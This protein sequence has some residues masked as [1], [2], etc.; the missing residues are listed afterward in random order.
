MNPTGSSA[1]TMSRQ[2]IQRNH[3]IVK[4]CKA[5]L[6]VLDQREKNAK[7]KL[8]AAESRI[9]AADS[10]M[11]AAQ[12]RIAAA[13]SQ[14]AVAQSRM[15]AA[16]SRIAVADS[17]IAAADSGI[18]AADS[19][20]ATAQALRVQAQALNSIAAEK[21]AAG[22]AML[23]EAQAQRAKKCEQ[24]CGQL[25]GAVRQLNDRMKVVQGFAANEEQQAIIAKLNTLILQ[26]SQLKREAI[27]TASLAPLI[28]KLTSFQQEC[29][30]ICSQIARMLV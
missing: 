17:G 25:D 2:D 14:M 30:S 1:P 24:I 15:A 29:V 12:S 6:V 5:R 13:D 26:A 7:L 10:Q 28:P 20:I 27:P 4:E 3:A 8:A 16:Q 21:R 22:E 11:A 18:A 23:A 9:A 19:G